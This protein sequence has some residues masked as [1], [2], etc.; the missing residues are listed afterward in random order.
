MSDLTSLS[1]LA[2]EVGPPAEAVG[3]VLLLY[4]VCFAVSMVMGLL[5]LAF[6]IWMI[7]DCANNEPNKGNDKLIWILI[8]VLTGWLGAAIYYFVRRP[9]RIATHGR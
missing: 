3:I 1:I 4:F 6:W 7:I 9:K 2:Q 8:I 5:L